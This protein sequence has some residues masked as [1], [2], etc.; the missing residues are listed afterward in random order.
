MKQPKVFLG[1]LV[2]IGIVIV[3]SMQ[4]YPDSPNGNDTPVAFC[5]DCIP[6]Y[7][8]GGCTY[9]DEN[10]GETVQPEGCFPYDTTKTK[11][12]CSDADRE[13]DA[14]IEIY[15]PVCGSDARTYPNSCFACINQNVAFFLEG[16]CSDVIL[17]Q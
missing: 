3:V 9:V 12:F 2:L 1:I 15:Q 13:V 4:E 16:E 17:S 10:T 7:I 8:G 6:G 14:C 5:I 11:Q